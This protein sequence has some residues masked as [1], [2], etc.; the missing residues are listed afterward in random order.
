MRK[1]HV[2]VAIQI[3]EIYEV[4]AEDKETASEWWADGDLIDTNDEALESTVL[5]VKEV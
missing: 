1:Y 2:A 3:L 4:E 5:S